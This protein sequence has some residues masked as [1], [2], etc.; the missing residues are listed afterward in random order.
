MRSKSWLGKRWLGSTPSGYLGLGGRPGS[1]IGAPSAG[2]SN[3]MRRSIAPPSSTLPPPLPGSG[4]GCGKGGSAYA[5]VPRL[6]SIKLPSPPPPLTPPDFKP[7]VLLGAPT[8]F[9]ASGEAM[10]NPAAR[11]LSA[12]A[13]APRRPSTSV[14]RGGLRTTTSG[15]ERAVTRSP[16]IASIESSDHGLAAS[17]ASDGPSKERSAWLISLAPRL[18]APPRAASADRAALGPRRLSAPPRATL[19][20]LTSS[21]AGSLSAASRS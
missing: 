10:P 6:G 12:R 17:W 3:E 16:Y 21:T 15:L 20:P 9:T 18:A 7:P 5:T 19:L 14:A 1:R 8:A 2:G 4:G 13:R 11:A